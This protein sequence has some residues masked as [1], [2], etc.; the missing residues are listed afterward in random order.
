MNIERFTQKAQEALAGAQ[1]QA[2]RYSHQQIEPEHLLAAL[3]EQTD[4]LIPNLMEGMQIPPSG[5]RAKVEEHLR[6][7]PQ[8]SGGG[9]GQV[10]ISQRMNRILTAAEEEAK[11]FK[12]DY[13]SVEHLLLAM[14]DDAGACGRILKDAGVTKD[15]LMKALVTIRGNQRVTSQNPEDTY[16]PLERYG[17]DLTQL[18]REGK[19]DPVIGRDEEI[20]RVIQILSRRTKNNPVLI[21]DPGVGKTAIVEGLAQRIVRGDVPEGLKNK[22]IV[23]LDMGALIAG[24]KYRGEFEE[25]LKAV[26]KEVQ[27]SEGEIILFIDELH[28]VVG[29]GAAEGAVD[30]SNLLKPMLARGEL[31]CVG[32]TTLDEYRKHIEKDAAL[33][34][35]FQPV[36]VDEPSVEETISILRGLKERYEVHHGVRIKDSAL[37]AAAILSHRYISDRFLPD[38]AIDLVDEAAAKIRTEI[39]SMPAQLDEITRRVMQLEIEREALKKEKDAASKE[40]LKR[41][42][43]ELADL[44][45]QADAL[46]AQ[47]ETEKGAIAQVRALKRE[48]EEARIQIEQAERDYNLNRAAELKYGTLT[49]LEQKLHAAEEH[50]HAKEGGS[51][52][53]KEEVDEEDIAMV[54]SRWTGVP[55]SRLLEGEKEKLLRL[56]DELH[57]RVVGQDEAVQAVADAVLR[58][59]SGIKDPNRPIGSFIFLGPTGVGKTELARALAEALFD[60]ENNMVRIDMSE[61]MEKHT[62]SRLIGAPPGYV[63]YEEGGQ[64]TE[65]VRRKPYSVIL[66][67]EIEKA[68]HDVFNILL[69]IL[70]DGRVTDSHGRTVDCKNTVI[71]MTSNIGS[72][73]ILEFRGSDDESYE[74]MKEQVLAAMRQHF[75]PEFL[76]RVDETVVFRSLTEEQLVAIVGI[77]TRHLQVRL[78]ER[79]ITLELTAEAAE[80]IAKAGYD[81]VYGARPLKRVIQREVETPLAKQIVEGKVLDNSRV[82]AELQK[83]RIVFR[84]E[85]PAVREAGAETARA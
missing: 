25:R 50:L 37:V 39:D 36:L 70:D 60:D 31:H 19:L 52:L 27:E 7:I 84:I 18:S 2:A 8:V 35:R 12:D 66:F 17:R 16:Q 28:T 79:G 22:R 85:P 29:A 80:H 71:I 43:K 67:D 11:R 81:P 24:A 15:G 32:A 26:L 58:A 21:G 1:A 13:T 20:R 64:L 23:T 76:N 5:V 49:D 44:K 48:I 41:L 75:R 9:T 59:R 77:Q 56:G 33:E 14:V 57:R 78:A 46:K 10:Y 45:A 54:V 42:E 34:R 47:W 30:A 55:V 53:L 74:R 51:M 65:A 82:I 38:K 72:S 3:L 62:V 69:Q 83:G 6:T 4:G 68:H 63:G 73:Y 61:Y 40:R